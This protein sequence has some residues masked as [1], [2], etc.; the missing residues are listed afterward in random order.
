MLR[1][2]QRDKYLDDKVSFACSVLG[3]FFPQTPNGG[4]GGNSFPPDPLQRISRS[5]FHGSLEITLIEKTW[6]KA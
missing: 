1:F 6:F 5:P 3:F 4:S 2:A